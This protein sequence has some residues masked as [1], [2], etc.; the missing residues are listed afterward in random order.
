VTQWKILSQQ[1]VA[2][3]RFFV[4]FVFSFSFHDLSWRETAV[5]FLQCLSQVSHQSK[6][7]SR[8][9]VEE[10]VFLRSEFRQVSDEYNPIV[11]VMFLIP[12][13]YK[14]I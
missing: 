6:H 2:E 14:E 10:N 1:F 7:A 11:T 12:M 9:K 4:S 13:P 5:I 8:G 3:Y